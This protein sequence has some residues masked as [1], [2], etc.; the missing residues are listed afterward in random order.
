MLHFHGSI[1]L[2]MGEEVG[3]LYNP[4]AGGGALLDIGL[5]ML[6]LASWVYGCR[7]PDEV[8][9]TS[10]MHKN[11]IDVS[12]LINL[13]CAPC[14]VAVRLCLLAVQLRLTGMEQAAA[15]AVLADG[16]CSSSTS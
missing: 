9:A 16:C 8:K 12:G 6:T 7:K 1:C 13:K 14:L 4:E 5:Y 2:P 3:R 11:G 10:V 15:A